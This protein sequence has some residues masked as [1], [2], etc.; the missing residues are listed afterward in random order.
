MLLAYLSH[1]Y[2]IIAQGSLGQAYPTS[3]H[4]GVHEDEQ[5]RSMLSANS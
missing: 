1:S 2:S 3:R 5:A 4:T